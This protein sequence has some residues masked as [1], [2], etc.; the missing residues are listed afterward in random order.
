M[1]SSIATITNPISLCAYVLFVVFY[2]LAKKWK[3]ESDKPHHRRLFQLMATLAVVSLAGGLFLAWRQQSNSAPWTTVTTV[4]QSSDGNQ[5]ANINSSGS[6]PVTVKIDPAQQ[7]SPA[8][9][10]GKK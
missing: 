3:V 5:N 8:P 9:A 6:G 4:V 7:Q 1:T 10:D 2:F